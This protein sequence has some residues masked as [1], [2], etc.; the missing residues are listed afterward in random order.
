MTRK[1][2]I[3]YL[4][5]HWNVPKK[6]LPGLSRKSSEE[7]QVLFVELQAWRKQ[8]EYRKRAEEEEKLYAW[9]VCGRKHT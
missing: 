7:L 2:L 4:Q 3:L 8:E 6:P 5:K 9:F 1:E